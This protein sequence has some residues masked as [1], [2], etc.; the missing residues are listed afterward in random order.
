MKKSKILSI[1]VAMAILAIVLATGVALAQT[2]LQ[3]PTQTPIP[4]LAPNPIIT[5]D[6]HVSCPATADNI[7]HDDSNCPKS[8]E[9][10]ITNCEDISD[11]EYSTNCQR[12]DRPQSDCSESGD[13]NGM[14]YAGGHN[15]MMN[16]Y[17]HGS[18]MSGFGEMM[19]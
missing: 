13:H 15:D 16:G 12:S 18:M 1:A 4:T 6:D 14:M 11:S 10:A 19:G 5:T 3:T 17:N 2:Q 7:A 9:S 8:G